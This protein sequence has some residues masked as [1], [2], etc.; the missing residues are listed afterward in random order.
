MTPEHFTF[1][2]GP[3]PQNEIRLDKCGCHGAHHIT[4]KVYDKERDV[5]TDQNIKCDQA[6]WRK[7]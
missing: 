2:A 4:C 3:A 5:L 7:C 6:K 1:S